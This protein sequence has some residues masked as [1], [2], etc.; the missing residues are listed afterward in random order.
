[1]F[2]NFLLARSFLLCVPYLSPALHHI[3]SWFLLQ[4]SHVYPPSFLVELL[5]YPNRSTFQTGLGFSPVLLF[6]VAR[7]FQVCPL[8]MGFVQPSSPLLQGLP[9]WWNW[10]V[11]FLQLQFLF[12]LEANLLVQMFH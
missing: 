9:P 8:L 12:L 7:S 4:T 2:Y 10:E 11:S 6:C 1:M 3:S 5:T